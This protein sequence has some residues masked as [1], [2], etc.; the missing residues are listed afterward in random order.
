MVKIANAT[1]EVAAEKSIAEIV[2]ILTKHGATE[3]MS[4]FNAGTAIGLTFF[5]NTKHGDLAFKLPANIDKIYSILI[6]DCRLSYREEVKARVHKQ[7]ERIAWRI[8][9]DWVRAQ[10]AI[11]QAEQVEIE[12]VFLPYLQL[13]NGK[14]LYQ[15]LDGGG[16][17]PLLQGPESS[18][19]V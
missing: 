6:E 13:N 12:Q 7:A 19:G 14:S 9:R 17:K 10:I 2:A 5:I 11:I 8:M 1:T 15:S 16:F 4:S 18:R 3:I